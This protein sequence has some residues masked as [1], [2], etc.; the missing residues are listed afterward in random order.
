[1]TLVAGLVFGLWTAVCP[2]CHQ[3][4][5]LK[6]YHSW[7]IGTGDTLECPRCHILLKPKFTIGEEPIKETPNQ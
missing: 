2:I 1:M 5:S 7:P 4:V 6:M 3:E